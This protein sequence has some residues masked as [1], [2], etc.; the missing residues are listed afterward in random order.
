MYVVKYIINTAN[1]QNICYLKVR[2]LPK[3]VVENLKSKKFVEQKSVCSSLWRQRRVWSRDCLFFCF[4][5]VPPLGIIAIHCCLC[6]T[7]PSAHCAPSWHTNYPLLHML[8]SFFCLLMASW[9]AMFHTDG[10][11]ALFAALQPISSSCSSDTEFS[12]YCC[13][14]HW[15]IDWPFCCSVVSSLMR[16]NQD[17]FLF[18]SC[19]TLLFID[20]PRESIS[21][22]V[23]VFVSSCGWL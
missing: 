11:W 20:S 19:T 13:L 6:C 7:L 1:W 15:F 2:W 9:Y 10:S 12:L 5:S 18:Y 8:R 21:S 14:L 4:K 23:S 16:L 3:G 17:L 22:S